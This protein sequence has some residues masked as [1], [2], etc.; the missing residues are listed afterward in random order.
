[1]TDQDWA[2]VPYG[3]VARS[4]VRELPCEVAG[5]GDPRV[6]NDPEVFYAR[7]CPVE[8]PGSEVNFPPIASGLGWVPSPRT[9]R[10]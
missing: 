8:Q 10:A 7:L 2:G 1:M 9:P 5:S 6:A 3:S 4:G